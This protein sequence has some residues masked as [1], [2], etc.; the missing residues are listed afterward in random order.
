MYQADYTIYTDGSAS[1]GTRNGG[2]AAVVTRGS[3]TEPEVVTTIKTKG[4]TYTSLYK[5]EAAG[6][7]S[8]LS[9]TSTNANH[10]PISI[11]ICTDSESL[12][13]ALV[14]SN[15]LASSIHNSINSTWSSIFIQWIPGHFAIPGN[16]LADKAAKEATTIAT[17]TILPVSFSSSI[18]VIYETIHDDPPTSQRVALI[19]QHQKA[20]RD[21]EQ[22]KNRKGEVLLVHL[23]SDHHPFQQYLHLLNPS[24]DPICPKC[25]LDEQDLHHWLYECP[26]TMTIRQ[27]VFGNHK[28]SLE[29]PAT[30]PGDVVV[31]ARKTLTPNLV[32]SFWLIYKHTHQAAFF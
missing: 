3:P 18:Q 30:R 32:T 25:R 4:R 16:N 2:A 27:Q 9:W 11:L 26:A 28:G 12:C 23:R 20:S 22:I 15:P 21:A 7:E 31:Y 8:A 17:N 10:L 13:E 14:S 29:W 1:R 5:E 24:Q 6:K 19:Y